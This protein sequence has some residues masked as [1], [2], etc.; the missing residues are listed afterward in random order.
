MLSIALLLLAASPDP[1]D[2]PRWALIIEL[3]RQVDVAGVGLFEARSR[4]VF[5]LRGPLSRAFAERCSLEVESPLATARATSFVDASVP[6]LF[7]VDGA[8]LRVKNGAGLMP[9][10]PVHFDL[11]V[12]AVGLGVM[13]ATVEGLLRL[14]GTRDG[15]LVRG[16][17]E[18]HRPRDRVDGPA[19][20]SLKL[21][22]DAL[23]RGTFTLRPT[24]APRCSEIGAPAPSGKGR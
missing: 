14:H 1:T 6:L 24:S 3:P 13:R 5:L 15:D 12:G 2:T 23:V 7:E 16:E 4:T 9:V 19:F 18:L 11:R 22:S 8:E 10:G 17:V 21:S 20:V